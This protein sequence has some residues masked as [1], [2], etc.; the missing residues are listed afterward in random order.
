MCVFTPDHGVGVEWL[1][2]RWKC[3]L[4]SEGVRLGVDICGYMN[5]K[6]RYGYGC[7]REWG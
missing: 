5:G 1:S 3:G 7:V 2:V 6:N 4:G